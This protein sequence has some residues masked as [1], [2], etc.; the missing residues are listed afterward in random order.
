MHPHI[1]FVSLNDNTNVRNCLNE[2]IYTPGVFD[3]EKEGGVFLGLDWES[4]LER[5][6]REGCHRTQV[7]GGH[8]WVTPSH[9]SRIVRLH[10]YTLC[11]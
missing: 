11:V 8:G 1:T 4:G 5:I 7:G 6:A 10:V 3:L 2:N 9:A